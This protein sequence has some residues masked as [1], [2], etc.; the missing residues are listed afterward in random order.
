MLCFGR[1]HRQSGS[2]NI[3]AHE[4]HQDARSLQLASVVRSF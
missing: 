2:L 1:V 4:Q 3:V